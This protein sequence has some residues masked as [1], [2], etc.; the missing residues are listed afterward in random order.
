[1][2]L[3]LCFPQFLTNSGSAKTYKYRNLVWLIDLEYNCYELKLE[4]FG[5]YLNEKNKECLGVV[6]AC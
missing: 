5:N 2:S 1:M 6:Q 4:V 3:I